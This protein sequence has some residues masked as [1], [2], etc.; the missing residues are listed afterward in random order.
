MKKKACICGIAVGVAL[1]ICGILVLSG[2]FIKKPEDPKKYRDKSGYMNFGGDAYTYMN[3]NLAETAAVTR[4]I[5]DATGI[6]LI[7]FGLLGVCLFTVLM[8]VAEDAEMGRLANQRALRRLTDL[9]ENNEKK[10]VSA[11]DVIRIAEQ[12]R[13]AE[14]AG[15]E[16]PVRTEEPI[17]PAE[18]IAAVS[19]EPVG[20][21]SEKPAEP[22]PAVWV[23][24]ARKTVEPASDQSTL[25]G[26]AAYALRFTTDD[27]MISYLNS[28]KGR[29]S[30]NDAIMLERTLD[31][32]ESAIRGA[33]KKLAEKG[34]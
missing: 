13:A 11:G 15:K 21:V 3:N 28:Q 27:G 19:A 24:R 20:T 6:F 18:P 33:L 22:I 30:A 7:G 34:K 8:G 17:V 29:L 9:A 16:E 12:M 14:S 23:L 10:K 25:A 5:N 32:P 26:L 4:S 1:V 31:L 2:T